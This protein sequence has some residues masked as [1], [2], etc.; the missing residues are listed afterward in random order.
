[1]RMRLVNDD[2]T[3]RPV[4]VE[5]WETTQNLALVDPQTQDVVAQI[6]EPKIRFCDSYIMVS[7]FVQ[8]DD[9][10]FCETACILKK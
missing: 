10:K 6:V 5:H 1:M 7:G 8:E 4:D 2:N 9:G 3:S